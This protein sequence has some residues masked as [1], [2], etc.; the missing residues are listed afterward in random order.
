MNYRSLLQ[1][2][3]MDYE[4]KYEINYDFD[5]TKY[6]YKRFAIHSELYIIANKLEH[7]DFATYNWYLKISV[8]EYIIFLDV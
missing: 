1:N 7:G 3:D 5:W 2:I 6:I 4:N 8:I